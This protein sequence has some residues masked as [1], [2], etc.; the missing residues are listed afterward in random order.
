MYN[1]MEADASRSDRHIRTPT[2]MKIIAFNRP[3]SR[4]PQSLA[5]ALADSDV[6]D[7]SAIPA[8]L[9]ADSAAVRP[10]HARLLRA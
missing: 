6:P 1:R 9:I 8:T 10:R 3:A 2:A 5:D 4:W 7:P